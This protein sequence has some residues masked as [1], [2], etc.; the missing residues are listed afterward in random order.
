VVSVDAAA[1]AR[2]EDAAPP[3]PHGKRTGEIVAEDAPRGRR[4]F[5]DGRA[6][7]ETPAI[8]VA[9]CGTHEV[10]VGSKGNPQTVDIPCGGRVSVRP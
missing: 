3:N 6:V 8:V 10:K 2:A 7:G 1:S 5:V 9:P 4:V